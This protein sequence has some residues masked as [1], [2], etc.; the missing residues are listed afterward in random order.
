MSD[1]FLAFNECLLITPIHGGSALSVIACCFIYR[2]II[3]N[4]RSTFFQMKS[5]VSPREGFQSPC[6]SAFRPQADLGSNR[7]NQSRVSH[8]HLCTGAWRAVPRRYQTNSMR[9]S[10]PVW[11]KPFPSDS[12]CNYVHTVGRENQSRPGGRK[13]VENE[14]KPSGE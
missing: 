5:W 10:L 3:Q 13:L 7:D 9:A 8:G 14:S 11:S 4:K 2:H 6:H 12:A 1:M